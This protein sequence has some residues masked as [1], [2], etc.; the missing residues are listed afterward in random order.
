[1]FSAL[2]NGDSTVRQHFYIYIYIFIN[3]YMLECI[4]EF[5]ESQEC[6]ANARMVLKL[7]RK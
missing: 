5:S 7:Q 3:N 2:I 6:E 4:R 1:M